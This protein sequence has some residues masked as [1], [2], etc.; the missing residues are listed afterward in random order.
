MDEL[1]LYW[2]L[3]DLFDVGMEGIVF[4]GVLCMM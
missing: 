3:V 4:V 2:W 1:L